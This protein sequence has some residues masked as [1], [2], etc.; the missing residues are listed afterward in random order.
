MKLSN[1]MMVQLDA[2]NDQPVVLVDQGTQRRLHVLDDD[3]LDAL[4]EERERE[5]WADLGTRALGERFKD[6][7]WPQEDYE[8]H[9]ARHQTNADAD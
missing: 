7:P 8:A 5:A 6:E 9:R 3:Q 4:L 2:P 1:G